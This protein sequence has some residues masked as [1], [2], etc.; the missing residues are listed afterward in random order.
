M[1]QKL[2]AWALLCTLT[3]FLGIIVHLR[4]EA[5]SP[6]REL[7]QPAHTAAPVTPTTPPLDADTS[8][9]ALC[10]DACSQVLMDE[11]LVG[12]LAGEMP[13]SFDIE[14][15]KAQAVAARTYILYKTRNETPAH[16][17]AAVCSDPACCKAH[18]TEA[19]MLEVWGADYAEYRSKLETAVS[20]TDGQYLVYNGSPIQAVFHSSSSGMTAASSELWGET[21]YLVSVS[22]PET[23]PDVPNFVSTA[24]ISVQSFREA[25]L[26]LYPQLQT[27]SDPALWLGEV[28]L[29]PS[30]RVDT[31]V[32]CSQSFTGQQLRQLF[33]LRS[34]A[35]DL[36][37]TGEAFLFT[38][39]GF[40]HG[41]GMSQYGANTLACRGADFAEILA[42][43]YPGTEL[44]SPAL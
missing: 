7:P 36:E 2:Y 9:S 32:I 13:A 15:L 38:V 42:H 21:P 18:L 27:D 6:A 25:L 43:Y 31:A 19:Q 8:F 14:A 39:R 33:F 22:S 16:P 12:V 37:Y 10:G 20:A 28:A 34:A 26:S 1:K 23:E 17:Q 5:E 41:V 35:F 40:G 29:T 3:F 30:G 24:E 11:Y 4:M 44:V